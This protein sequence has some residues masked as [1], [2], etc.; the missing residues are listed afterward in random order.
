MTICM[1]CGKENESCLCVKCRTEVDIEGLCRKI[2]EYRQGSNENEIWEKLMSEMNSP[3]NFKNIAFA[4]SDELPSPRKEYMKVMSLTGESSNI[5]KDSRQWIYEIYEAVKDADGLSD[6]EKLRLGG[7][8]LG[9]LYMDYDY[10]AADALADQLSAAD[11]TPWQVCYNLTKFYTM[12][13]RYD[14]ADDIISEAKARFADNDFVV[15]TMNNLAEDNAKYVAKAN[16]GKQE[17]MPNPKENR[18]EIRQKYVDFL[19]SIGIE[20]KKPSMEKK[21]K[22][23]IPRDEYPNPVET[24]DAGIDTFVAFDLETTGTNTKFDSIVEIGAVKVVG[25]KVVDSEEFTFQE[26]V[27]PLDH[28]KISPEAQAKNGLTDEEV[29]AARPV[30]EVF[31]D[32]MKFAGDSVLL[33]FN[34]MSF[35]SKLMVRAGRYSNLIT[36]NKY[37]DV[38]HYAAHFSEQLGLG[39]KFSLE[40]L[41]EKLNVENPRAHRALADA[42]TTARIFLELKKLDGGVEAVSVEDMLSDLDEW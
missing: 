11:D 25:G 27:K 36:E 24:R 9:A 15:N 35:D 22:G 40:D 7:I 19:A 18:D 34:C 8:V 28:K 32:F 1:N 31:P 30:W 41:S 29:Y 12:T 26:L 10:E 14:I 2:I 6:A 39:K 5:N 17:Y 16:D 3:Y 4:I 20:A 37:F 33:G 42:L 21:A 13:R 23:V 38:M